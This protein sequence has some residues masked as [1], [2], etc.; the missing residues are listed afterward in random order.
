MAG[1]MAAI[2]ASELGASV[3][4]AV[5][6]KVGRSG[7]TP[8]GGG[9]GGADFMVDSASISTV[10]GLND[11]G[12][13]HPDMRDTP[14]L[15]REDVL[16]E[17]GQLNNQRMVDVY[18]SEAPRR[19]KR[20]MDLGLRISSIDFAHGS[21]F[22]RGV[23]VL[24]RDIASTMMRV[25]AGSD[26]EVLEDTRIVDLLMSEGRCVGGVGMDTMSGGLVSVSSCATVI[27]TGGWHMAYHSGG[28]DELTGDG[29]A[30]AVRAGAELVDME[31]GTFMDRYLVWPPMGSRDNFIW[32]WMAPRGLVNSEGHDMLPGVE[33]VLLGSSRRVS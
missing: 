3:I 5:E 20:L 29:Q 13:Q 18:V 14:L 33:G 4:L 10:L 11:L 7:C 21:R 2:E 16:S 26:V 28:S 31:F 25:I 17:G 27:A 22:P 12:P 8:L 1:F 15:F 30:M 23:I 24:N 9:P 19:M 32:N 6:G